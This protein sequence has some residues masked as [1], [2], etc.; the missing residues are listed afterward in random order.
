MNRAITKAKKRVEKDAI[1]D[2]ILEKATESGKK[3]L[4]ELFK[5]LGFKEVYVDIE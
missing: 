2:G 1:N 5:T 3:Q 4:T